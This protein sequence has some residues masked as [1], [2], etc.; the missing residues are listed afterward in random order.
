MFQIVVDSALAALRQMD[1]RRIQEQKISE[2]W[3]P[4]NI[5]RLEQIYG[6]KLI[7]LWHEPEVQ[8]IGAGADGFELEN[9]LQEWRGQHRLWEQPFIVRIPPAR[10]GPAGEGGEN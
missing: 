7:A 8:V 5:W 4:R 2:E 6:G 1:T 10:G 3:L 9:V